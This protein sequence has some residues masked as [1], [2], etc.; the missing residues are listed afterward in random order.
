[1]P[2]RRRIALPALRLRR[3]TGGRDGTHRGG[4]R[5]RHSL[6]AA[7]RTGHRALEQDEGLP[8][9]GRGDGHGRGEPEARPR[10]RPE[11]LRGRGPD[12]QG[13]RPQAHTSSYQQPDEGRR[14][15]RLRA[16]EHRARPDRDGA[17]RPQRAVPEDE[18][19]EAEPRLREVLE[20]FAKGSILFAGIRN[21]LRP[22][23][24]VYY[25]GG[26]SNPEITVG[27]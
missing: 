11:R 3:T 20:W 8:S 14:T 27:G 17:Q 15:Q 2:D 24:D 16:G 13:S 12:P 19:R 26:P 5:R 9:A 1:M 25:P 21:F 22:A 23:G 7:G 6:H 18:A 4:R 10:A